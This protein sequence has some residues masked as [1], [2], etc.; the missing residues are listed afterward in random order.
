MK[1]IEEKIG[2]CRLYLGDMMD[3][4]PSLD[5]PVQ[6]VVTDPPYPLTA[7]GVSDNRETMQ[8]IFAADK[9]DNGGKIVT[10]EIS[11]KDFCPV[12]YDALDTGSSHCYMFTNDKNMRDMLNA[13]HDSGFRL[14]NILSWRKPTATPN[15]WY[16]KN[17]EY[18]GFFFKGKARPIADCGAMQS[19]GAPSDKVTDHP[20]EKPVSVFRNYIRNSARHGDIV[21]DPFMGS[22]ASAVA[23]VKENRPFFGIEIEK[24]W[25]D[26]ACERVEKAVSGE[27]QSEMAI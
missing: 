16:M 6:C 13:A 4:L 20:T 9:Y 3:V 5:T 14:H 7:G 22:G 26:V 11:W 12:I 24:R 17:T 15:R 27:T 25:F 10:C 8:G 2:N 21:L 18:I 19:I 23:A 1:M